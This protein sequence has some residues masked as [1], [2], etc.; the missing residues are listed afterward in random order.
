VNST[1][2]DRVLAEYAHLREADPDPGL[3]AV[4]IAIFLEDVF[5]VTLRDEQIDVAVLSDADALRVL[6]TGSASPR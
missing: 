4:R 2:V 5:G 6:L 3:E 1:L